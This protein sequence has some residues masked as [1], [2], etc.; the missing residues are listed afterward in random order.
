[1]MNAWNIA[2]KDAFL[3]FA[4]KY[5]DYMNKTDKVCESVIFFVHTQTDIFN[6]FFLNKK[7]TGSL[8]DGQDFWVFYNKN[9]KCD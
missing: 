8:G 1:M 9:E 2:E 6:F 3:K 7:K 5:F 4:P